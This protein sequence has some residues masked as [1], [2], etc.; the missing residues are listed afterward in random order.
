MI[1]WTACIIFSVA[2]LAV[3][4]G[5]RADDVNM[6][7]ANMAVAALVNLVFVILALRSNAE[8]RARDAS[9]SAIAADGAKS[10]SFIWI[11]GVLGL[12]VIYGTGILQW[13]EWW[14]FLLAFMAAG[15]LCI[16]SGMMLQRRAATGQDDE[17]LLKQ[18]HYATIGQLIGM[19]AIVA[20][21]L[22]DG[23]M[24]RF[25]TERYTD[26]AANNI[27]FFG[28]AALGVVSLYIIMTRKK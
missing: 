5:A 14:H 19:I 4:A 23:K 15:G 1:I 27:F 16:Y 17:G 22:I 8:L 13:K 3:T 12:A 10:M 7:Y 28:A 21:L 9:R 11:W 6:A 26:W 25:F 18:G 20:G 2:L 24:M